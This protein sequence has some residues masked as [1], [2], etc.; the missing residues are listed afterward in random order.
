M[1]E[2]RAATSEHDAMGGP[3]AARRSPPAELRFIGFRLGSETFLIDIM[4]VRQI[5]PYKGSTPV[6]AAPSFVEGV[7]VAGDQA[8]PVIDVHARLMPQHTDIAQEPLVVLTHTPA[9]TIGLKV[10]DVRRIVTLTPQALLPAPATIRGIRGD[11]LVAIAPQDNEVFLVLDVDALLTS[12]E[13]E[14]LE[15]LRT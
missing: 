10:D 4:A 11:S 9:G 6:P 12:H 7:I 3:P 8:V 5:V 15:G 1:S 2:R 14:Q 13:Q